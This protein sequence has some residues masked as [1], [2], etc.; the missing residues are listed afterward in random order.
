[1]RQKPVPAARRCGALP[2]GGL[3]VQQKGG[4]EREDRVILYVNQFRLARMPDKADD[5]AGLPVVQALIRL[6]EFHFTA[7]VTFFAGE[8]GSGKST[9]L[10]SLAVC[11]GLNAESGSRNFRFSTKY[12]VSSLQQNEI[13]KAQQQY[14]GTLP[15]A[16]F[17]GE[18]FLHL[19]Y[20]RFR[21]HGLYIMDEPEAALSP[22]RRRMKYMPAF[23]LALLCRGAASCWCQ[24]QPQETARESLKCCQH[25]NF[26]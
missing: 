7:P 6:R 20:H 5:I 4:K 24:R 21:G 11:A 19:V 2:G 16:Q 9:L 23:T 10:E 25:R 1:M 18:S 15:H 8:N 13:E 14:G 26:L 22:R 12:T 3:W 17:H